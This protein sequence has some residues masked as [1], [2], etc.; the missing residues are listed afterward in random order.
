M[1]VSPVYTH[2]IKPLEGL[3]KRP[4]G[5]S[6][7]EYLNL[8]KTKL[9]GFDP[10]DLREA[11]DDIA[12]KA[13]SQTWPLPGFCVKACEAAKAKRLAAEKPQTNIPVPGEPLRMPE[14][15]ALRIIAAEDAAMGLAACDGSWIV[16][17][18]EFVQENKRMPVGR[19]VDDVRAT[20]SRVSVRI[21]EQIAHAGNGTNTFIDTMLSGVM[22]KRKR[23]AEAM[24]AMLRD[25]VA[26]N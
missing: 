16:S 18:L 22:G 20:A 12:M 8:L 2:F 7:K 13:E 24:K 3:F 14:D 10:V 21:E 4:P 19:E 15:A 23:I 1:S 11:A 5:S 25:P 26:S 6:E 17:L 9:S